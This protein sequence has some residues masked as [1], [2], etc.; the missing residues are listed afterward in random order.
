MRIAWKI[1][2]IAAVW[3]VL[4]PAHLALAADEGLAGNAQSLMFSDAEQQAIEAALAVRPAEELPMSGADG[5]P[6]LPVNKPVWQ[7]HRLHLSAL[8]YSGPRDWTLWF[9]G[10]QVKRGN[11]PPF[12]TALRVTPNYV[13]LSVI[14]RPGADP[15][16][17][18]LRP[19]Q[20]FL[21]KQL[22][23]AEDGGT[24]Y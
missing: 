24:E 20:T 17:A 22:R 6:Q 19:N 13:D 12:L 10:R 15:I 3:A 4:A 1:C 9:D 5:Q 2:F 21:I 8:V 11:V 7:I 23:V 18:R 16:P 14:P